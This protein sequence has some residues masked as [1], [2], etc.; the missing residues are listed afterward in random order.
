[1]SPARRALSLAAAALLGGIAAC[2]NDNG[3][4]ATTSLSATSTTNAVST[5]AMLLT[6]QELRLAVGGTD[7]W[8]V[9][10]LT[11]EGASA[12][13]TQLPCDDVTLEPALAERLTADAVLDGHRQ[14]GN[15]SMVEF[16]VTG[17]ES[18]LH[19]D[20][21]VYRRAQD[22]CATGL[23][24]GPGDPPVSQSFALPQLGDERHGEVGVCKGWGI[25]SRSYWAYVRV[26][27]VVV[28]VGACEQPVSAGK[29]LLISEPAFVKLLRIA[30]DKVSAA[31]QTGG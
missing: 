26:K 29:P 17:D 6:A 1:M 10:Q 30:V 22:Q 27:G 21:E 24:T 13:F 18:Q 5:A 12:G 2:S 8:K 3:S 4:Q 11:D 15:A 31:G 7:T 23:P 28:I 20:L 16:L 25:D 19:A 14:D 9:Q